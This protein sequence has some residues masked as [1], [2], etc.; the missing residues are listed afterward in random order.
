MNFKELIDR[1]VY[2]I[3]VPK[4]ICCAKI[5]DFDD[6]AICKECLSDYNLNKSK[7]C[8]L[9]KNVYSECTCSND[10]LGKRF[11]KKL[12]KVYRYKPSSSPNEKIPSNELI[13]QIKRGYRKDIVEFLAGEVAS[14]IS[15]NLKYENYIITSVPR[16]FGR[17]IKY[18]IDH[19]ETIARAVAKRLNIDYYQFLKSKSKKAQKKTHGEER[20]KNISFDYKNE[21][22][23]TGE[24]IIIFDD[25]VTTGASMGGCAILLKGLG[26]KEIVGA[27]ISIAYKDKYIPFNTDDRFYLKK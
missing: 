11:V 4:C 9:C 14:V 18:G 6:R 3:T 7:Q 26:A 10:Y 21:V 23:L 19:S 13:Y 16:S 12:C 20:F 8:S 2:Y 22:D 15:K 1:M 27:S 24:R 17:R 5:L 25:I